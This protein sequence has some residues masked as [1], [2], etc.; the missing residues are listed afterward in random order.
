MHYQVDYYDWKWYKENVKNP[1]SILYKYI[2]YTIRY[3]FLNR[4]YD[5]IIVISNLLKKHFEK[6]LLS[7][8]RVI[9]ILHLID[10]DPYQRICT[11][12]IFTGKTITIGAIGPLTYDNGIDDLIMSF[13]LIQKKYPNSSLVLIGGPED[14]IHHYMTITN[15]H[16]IKHVNFTGRKE[17]KDIPS[18]L[19]KC[20]ILVLARPDS[21]HTSAGFPTKL[22][23]YLSSLRPV[24]LTRYGDMETYL[25][26]NEHVVFADPGSVASI[27]DAIEKLINDQKKAKQIAQNGHEWVMNNLYYIDKT[28]ELAS[29]IDEINK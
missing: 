9:H 21:I 29:L 14:A 17:S 12:K 26:D 6:L 3:R 27:T 11:R 22:G 19:N 8:N 25:C 18:I 1:I 2:S 15:E 7:K 24:V 5:G 4:F 28:K 23:E 20:D 10:P 13:R 16:K